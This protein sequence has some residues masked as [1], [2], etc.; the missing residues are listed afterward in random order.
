MF[1]PPQAFRNEGQYQRIQGNPLGLRPC[2]KLSMDRLRNTCDKLA[3]SHAVAVGRRHRKALC[4]PC[5]DSGR[6]GIMAV[7]DGLLQRLAVG[8]AL[9]KIQVGNQEAATLDS[10]QGANLER[11]KSLSFLMGQS[12]LTGTTNFFT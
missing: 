4:L 2:G 8:K 12:P 3:G 1:T 6:Q 5:F 9:G 7:G 11:V 10:G